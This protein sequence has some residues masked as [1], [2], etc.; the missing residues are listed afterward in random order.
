MNFYRSSYSMFDL[1]RA[2][3]TSYTA[4]Q[5]PSLH[6]ACW[7]IFAGPHHEASRLSMISLFGALQV[8]AS[9]KVRVKVDQ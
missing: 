2:P 4:S 1:R 9:L 7:L 8:G 3:Q 5:L 6:Y